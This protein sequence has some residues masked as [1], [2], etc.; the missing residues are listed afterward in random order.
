MCSDKSSFKDQFNN[1]HYHNCGYNVYCEATFKKATT[2]E[3]T[4]KTLCKK[5]FNALVKNCDRVKR[6]TN[7]NSELTHIEV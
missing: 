1:I 6:M 5:H 7:F 4:T 2:G 3:F